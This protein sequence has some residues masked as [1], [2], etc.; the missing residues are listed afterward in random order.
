MGHGD[1]TAH[2]FRSTF[3][4]WAADILQLLVEKVSIATDGAEVRL[5]AEGLASVI[6]DITAQTGDRSAA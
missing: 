5:R 2:G 6:A 1:L 3:R 4:D